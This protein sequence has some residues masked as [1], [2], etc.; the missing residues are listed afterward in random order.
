MCLVRSSSKQAAHVPAASAGSPALVAQGLRP[1]HRSV[2]ASSSLASSSATLS[3]RAPATL[4]QQSGSRQGVVAMAGMS[5]SPSSQ[6]G[7]LPADF[8]QSYIELAHRLADT[9]AR[10]TTQYFR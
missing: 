10:V 1:A 7:G 4:L 9:A 3:K 8:Q 5:P 6:S 2:S